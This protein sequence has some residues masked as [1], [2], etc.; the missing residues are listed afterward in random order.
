MIVIIIITI[1]TIIIIIIIII[2][3]IFLLKYSKQIVIYKLKVEKRAI[4]TYLQLK[5]LKPIYNSCRLKKGTISSTIFFWK[6]KGKKSY[7]V[8]IVFLFVIKNHTIYHR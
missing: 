8:K 5:L 4:K 1:I 6:K 2:I 7:H 3:K